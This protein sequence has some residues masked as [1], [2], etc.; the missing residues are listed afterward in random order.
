MIC[1]DP[2]Y[3]ISAMGAYHHPALHV[4]ASSVIITP[5]FVRAAASFDF[6]ESI[7][8]PSTVAATTTVTVQTSGN[9]EREGGNKK[10]KHT[11]R[12]EVGNKDNRPPP[13]AA[14]PTALGESIKQHTSV[15]RAKNKDLMRENKGF[16]SPS[17]TRKAVVVKGDG[18]LARPE[19]ARDAEDTTRKL[20]E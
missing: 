17:P 14:T 4:S 15:P 3:R 16:L 6:S 1:P 7:P 13:R 5:H 20:T 10:K 2:A 12:R 8:V 18:L 19:N 11:K 9:N